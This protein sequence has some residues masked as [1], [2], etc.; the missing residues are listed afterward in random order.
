MNTNAAV[1]SETPRMSRAPSLS[2]TDTAADGARWQAVLHRSRRHDGAFV[3][4]VA[5]TGVYCR[6]SCP[7]RRPAR[8]HVRF[9]ER[10]DDAE[11][12]GFRPCLRCRPRSPLGD[13]ARERVEKALQYL[14][15]HVED[16][17]SLAALA[18][19]AGM[20]SSHLQR[21]FTRAFGVSPREWLSLKRLEGLKGRLRDGEPLSL[22]TYEAGFGSSRGVYALSAKRLGMTP[23]AYARGGRGQRIRYALARSPLGWLLVAATRRG[24]C[25]VTPGDGI[26]ALEASLRREF[27]EARLERERGSNGRVSRWAAAMARRLERGEMPAV[28]LDL[29]GTPFQLA[30][31]R[32]LREIPYGE[33][34]S[35]GEIAARIGRPTA[36][37]AVGRACAGNRAA[38]LVPC[39]RAIPVMGGTGG[40]RWGR[41]RKRAL[42]AIERRRAREGAA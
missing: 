40:Y 24:V 41:A 27:P 1:R 19:E 12:A 33:T 25:A 28:Q 36:A 13:P 8:R 34:R 14:T 26:R 2:L 20:S 9:F 4:A 15:A 22:A 6:P 32:A 31:W 10:A 30:V 39:H 5:S 11:R 37:R 35:Y 29:A 3:Y 23:G 16:R 42:L 18:R 17:P 38:L 7:S 21:A